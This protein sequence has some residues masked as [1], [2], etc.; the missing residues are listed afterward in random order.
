MLRRRLLN[1]FE[2]TP[3]TPLPSINSKNKPFKIN[4]SLDSDNNEHTIFQPNLT[5]IEKLHIFLYLLSHLTLEKER[6]FD[7]FSQNPCYDGVLKG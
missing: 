7:N 1:W 3:H 6:I 5:Q 4:P 2:S